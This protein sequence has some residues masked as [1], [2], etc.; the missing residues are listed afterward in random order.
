MKILL[1]IAKTE[2][3]KDLHYNKRPP[4]HWSEWSLTRGN[5]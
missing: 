1:S 5:R 4:H 2:V 3:K